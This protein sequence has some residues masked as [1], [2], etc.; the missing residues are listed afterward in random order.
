MQFSPLAYH[1]LPLSTTLFSNIPHSYLSVS[2]HISH[3]HKATGKL[4]MYSSAFTF[5]DKKRTKGSEMDSNTVEYQYNKILGTS[6][7]SL[8]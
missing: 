7:I 2:N 5:L 4:F 3:P 8:L 6:E 1:F